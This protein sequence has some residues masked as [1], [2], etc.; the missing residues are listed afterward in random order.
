VEATRSSE[1]LVTM[2]PRI[3]DIVVLMLIVAILYGFLP[4]TSR[5][6]LLHFQD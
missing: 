1:C 2:N 5:L 6:T 4:W 3:V